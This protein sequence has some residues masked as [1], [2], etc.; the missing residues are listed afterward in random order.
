MIP[1]AT[2][3]FAQRIRQVH[4]AAGAEWL[5]QLPA[6][7][8]HHERLWSIT[9]GQPLTT[10]SYN[11][12]A[13]GVR[14]D[15]SEVVL[16]LGVPNPELLTEIQA[17]RLFDGRGAVRLLEADGERGAMLLERLLPGTPLVSLADDRKATTV[18]AQVMRRLWRPVPP[19]HSFPT[20][21]RWAAGLGRLRRRFDGGTGPFPRALVERA[22]RLFEELIGSMDE[23]VLLHG[24]LHHENIL[25]ARRQPWLAVDPKGVV[26]EPAYEVGALLRNP[27][28][29]LLS[30]PRLGHVLARRADQLADAL[31]FDRQRLIGWALAQAVLAAWWD[32]ED[33]GH[34]WDLWLSC[35]EALAE[36]G[37]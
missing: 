19:D 3:D 24:D 23:A 37:P 26:G 5:R 32:Y 16:K 34:G 30:F 6:L 36:I 25:S 14:A 12:V 13:P 29:E 17:L 35:A 11:Y 27:F 28:P 20:V 9:V 15:G 10:L 8:R 2:E 21:V 31:G 1:A 33:H 18:A 7:V 4:G 22:E